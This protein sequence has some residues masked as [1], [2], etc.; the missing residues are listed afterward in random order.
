MSFRPVAV[1]F[2]RD[3]VE[4][5]MTDHPFAVFSLSKCFG[6]FEDHNLADLPVVVEPEKDTRKR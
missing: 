2:V 6:G 4:T 3:A 5:D 1:P